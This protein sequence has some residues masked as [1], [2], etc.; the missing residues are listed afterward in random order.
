MRFK[1]DKTILLLIE[2]NRNGNHFFFTQN[3]YYERIEEIKQSKIT[4]STFGKK[5]FKKL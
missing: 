3:K 1:F 4:L 5:V 2:K